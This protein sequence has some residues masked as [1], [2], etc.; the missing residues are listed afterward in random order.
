MMRVYSDHVM[1]VFCDRVMR[2]CC[3]NL[4]R[5]CYICSKGVLVSPC[6]ESV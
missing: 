6:R 4:I 3:D 1:R 2:V 5:M